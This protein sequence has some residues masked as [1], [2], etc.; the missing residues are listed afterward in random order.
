MRIQQ[1]LTYQQ[2]FDSLANIDKLGVH[3]AFSGDDKDVNVFPEPGHICRYNCSQL[4]P[5]AVSGY[6]LAQRFRGDDSH[7]AVFRRSIHGDQHNK[8]VGSRSSCVPHPLE[9]GCPSYSILSIH[10]IPA[11]CEHLVHHPAQGVG[12]GVLH[13]H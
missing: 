13:Y 9:I 8:R 11:R 10:L 1:F 3:D 5:Y 7:P 6:C 4:A 2:K 12:F